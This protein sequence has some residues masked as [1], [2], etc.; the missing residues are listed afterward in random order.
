[1]FWRCSRSPS[2][3]NPGANNVCAESNSH[4]RDLGA[5]LAGEKMKI[6]GDFSRDQFSKAPHHILHGGEPVLVKNGAVNSKGGGEGTVAQTSHP[7]NGVP[8]PCATPVYPSAPSVILY[9][10]QLSSILLVL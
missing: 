8:A 5:E 9:Q 10:S 1:M 7:K 2:T 4:S 3:E 6:I